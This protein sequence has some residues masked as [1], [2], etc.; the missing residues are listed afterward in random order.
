MAS[1]RITRVILE[2]GPGRAWWFTPLIA[3]LGRQ[4]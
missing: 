2:R 1:L 3:A 4:R